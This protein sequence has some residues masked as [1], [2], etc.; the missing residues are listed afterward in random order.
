M[1]TSRSNKV[2]GITLGDP[3][4]I[5]PEITTKSLRHL[6][7]NKKL[8]FQII[9]DAEIYRRYTPKVNPDDIIDLRNPFAAKILSGRPD[10]QSAAAG[11]SYLEKA[12][13]LLRQKKIQA[14]VTA[15]VSKEGIAAFKPKFQGHTEYLAEA[16]G[17]KKFG[18]MFVT[19]HLKTIIVTRHIPLKDV[20]RSINRK[21]VYETIMLADEALKRHFKIKNPSIAICGLNPHAGEGGRIGKEELFKIIPAVQKAKR[22]R[23]NVIGPLAA[24]TLFTPR[25]IKN[26]DAVVAMYHDQ[27]LIPVKTLYLD[28]LVNFTVGL[29][30]VRTSPAHGTAFN[31]AGK[32]IADC[33]S[34]TAAIKL[35]VELL[36]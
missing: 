28:Q 31:I 23:I 6:R 25:V 26:Y 35:A 20:S 1:P 17:V 8:R 2:I 5:G 27:G 36:S 12:V 24:D 14:L 30:F 32:G 11:L 7:I 19:R 18:M 9:G 21:N 22:S 10:K 33:S 3:A 34:M 4:G 13:E 16:F 29:P 15:P